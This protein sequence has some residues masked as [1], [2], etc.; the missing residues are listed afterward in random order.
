MNTQETI[1]Q[2]EGLK[3]KGMTECYKALQSIPVTQWPTIDTFIARL[4]KTER[5]RS[6]CRGRRLMTQADSCA[7]TVDDKM[8]RLYPLNTDRSTA[9]SRLSSLGREA[10]ER[11][12]HRLFI[13]R[14]GCCTGFMANGNSTV[15]GG[16]SRLSL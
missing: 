3:L 16:F 5:E 7:V 8:L 12:E 1:L 4:A 10:R 14:E 15:S 11:S 13:G 9:G 2:L 6:L